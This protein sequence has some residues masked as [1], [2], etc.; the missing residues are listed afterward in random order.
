VKK[1]PSA[2]EPPRVRPKNKR[3]VTRQQWLIRT[4]NVT[5]AVTDDL[6]DDTLL[7]EILERLAGDRAIDLQ[8]IDEHGDGDEAVGLH[9]LLE[10]V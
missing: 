3:Y 5:R 7:L 9:I 4:V 2:S 1:R 10:S 8:S 6:L